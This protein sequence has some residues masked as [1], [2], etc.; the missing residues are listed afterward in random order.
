MSNLLI[1]KKFKCSD[2][3]TELILIAD[4]T[5]AY[6]IIVKYDTDW[7]LRQNSQKRLYLKTPK[8]ILPHNL[9]ELNLDS[10][11]IEKSHV[12]TWFSTVNQS[13]N[14]SVERT[15]EKDSIFTIFTHTKLFMDPFLSSSIIFKHHQK[16]FR[17]LMQ[18]IKCLVSLMYVAMLLYP[19]INQFIMQ[20]HLKYR[21][22]LKW[23]KK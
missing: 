23:S 13:N 16:Q 15:I 7:Q 14:R 19:F 18:S 3:I 11:V 21:K 4:S 5:E 6:V 17:Y 12:T 1:D 8:L 10:D 22:T 9:Y 20:L 2:K